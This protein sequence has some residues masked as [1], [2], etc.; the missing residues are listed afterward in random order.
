MTR[1]RTLVLQ[2]T[3]RLD[4]WTGNAAGT[5]SD[6]ME[7]VGDLIRDAMLGGAAVTVAHL[8]SSEGSWAEQVAREAMPRTAADRLPGEGFG[9]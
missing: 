6:I 7:T 4:E 9:A 5:D 3:L 2:V 1:P 8:A